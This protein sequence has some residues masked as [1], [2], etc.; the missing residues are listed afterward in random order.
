MTVVVLIIVHMRHMSSS[1]TNNEPKCV[2]LIDILKNDNI[3]ITISDNEITKNGESKTKNVK[4]NSSTSK[5]PD[6]WHRLGNNCSYWD[7][8]RNVR[9]KPYGVCVS[10]E[11]L[12]INS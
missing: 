9:P 2:R 1:S 3:M 8:N 6:I 7:S 4:R 5:S 11:N 10:T 12:V